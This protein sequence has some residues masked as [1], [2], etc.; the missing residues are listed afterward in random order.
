MNRAGWCAALALALQAPIAG[1]A[2]TDL[3]ARVE[4]ADG[5]VAWNVPMIENVGELC[6]FSLHGHGK[7]R[8][9][10][11]LDGRNI[12]F[13]TSDDARPPHT[14]TLSVYVHVAH[15]RIDDVR[16]YAQ[17]CPVQ[18][19]GELHWIDRVEPRQSI[20][21]LSGWLDGGD[22]AHA[23]RDLAVAAIAYHA[24]AS[25]TQLLAARA[26]PSHPRKE[27][28]DALFWL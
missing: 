6:C 24:D 9:G 2:E 16:A 18:S 25:A 27:R 12:G 5:W 21:V 15:A 1:V 7:A 13:G 3:L 26:E 14:S 8:S 22:D 23:D 28:E 10:C 4:Q 19:T 17:T 20:R 11:D